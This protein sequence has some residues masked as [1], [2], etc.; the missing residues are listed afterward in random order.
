MITN[1]PASAPV[2]TVAVPCYNEEANLPTAVPR[3][4]SILEAIADPVE[5]LFV[6]DGS[7]DRTAD[8]IRQLQSRYPVRLVD[9]ARNQGWGGAVLEGFEAARGRYYC[10]VPADEQVSYE[11]IPVIYQRIREEP[12]RTVVKIRRVTRTNEFERKVFSVFYNA[13]LNVVFGFHSPD[14][15]GTPKV[16][17]RED[18]ERVRPTF[19]NNF[20]DA[21]LLI[22]AGRL[23][24]RVVE[25]DAPSTRR[26]GGASHVKVVKESLRMFRD[27][28]RFRRQPR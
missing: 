18:F 27:M 23:K 22:N 17:R 6:N 26:T 16:L 21:E 2:L 13:L 28:S 5:L 12:E 10:F 14:H 1:D 15:N 9:C 11:T 25:I 20:F 24:Y 19:K 7:A 4:V 8:V 3:L